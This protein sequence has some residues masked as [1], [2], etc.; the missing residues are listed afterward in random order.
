MRYTF[1][2]PGIRKD[3]PNIAILSF[4]YLLQGIPLG[5]TLGSLPFLL[6]SRLSFSQMAIFSLAGYP[7]SLKLLWSPLVDSLFWR[8]IGRRKSWVLPVQIVTAAVMWWI[9]SWVDSE[10]DGLHPDINLL[11][12]SFTFLVMLSATQ[13]VAVDGWAIEALA[14]ENIEYASTAQ[15][16]GLNSGYFLSFTVF[17]AL[18]SPEF[19]SR[20]LSFLMTDGKGVLQLG[21][22]LR[23]WS[24]LYMVATACVSQVRE[25]EPLEVES[26]AGVYATVLRISKMPN[27]LVLL[28]LLFICKVPF[29]LN[30]SVTALKLVELGVDRDILAAAVLIDFPIQV[31]V[32]VLAARWAAGGGAWRTWLKAYYGRLFFAG[33]GVIVV[34][35]YPTG[36]ITNSYLSIVVASSVMSSFVSTVQF[37]SLGSFF[38][39]IADP[40]VGGTYM[41]LLN[42]FSNLGGTWAKPIVLWL[43]DFLTVSTCMDSNGSLGPEDG[44][45]CAV[46][47]SAKLACSES[48]GSCTVVRDGYYVVGIASV[49]L[50]IA[51]LRFAI[52]PLVE[53]VNAVPT[54]KWAVPIQRK[55]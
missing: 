7:Y 31:V 35:A 16:L 55:S 32:G 9:S 37:V 20:Y 1:L 41:T 24:L 19:C 33:V 45:G 51:L 22:Y 54:H 2:T 46:N 27:M 8:S 11:T 47:E 53:S 3:L 42:T 36:G 39:T 49:L 40:T 10:V 21:S 13:D 52:R 23:F 43:V 6:K 4:L 50:G 14:K 30:E 29:T 15:T 18:N 17:L 5:V 38:A 48:G 44:H 12:I 34:W 28:A 26:A 25:R